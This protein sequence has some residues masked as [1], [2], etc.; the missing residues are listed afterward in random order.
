MRQ[1]VQ[2][3]LYIFIALHVS[4][5][6]PMVLSISCSFFVS[7]MGGFSSI[8]CPPMPVKGCFLFGACVF[9]VVPARFLL[10]YIGCVVRVSLYI[11]CFLVPN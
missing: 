8:F 4:L 5:V 7:F 6:T 11:L 1:V 3:W 9:L 10:G 2:S